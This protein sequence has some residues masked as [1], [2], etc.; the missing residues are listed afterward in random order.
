M[1]LGGAGW[2]G[3]GLFEGEMKKDGEVL[4]EGR[5]KGLKVCTFYT[6]LYKG[7]RRTF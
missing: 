1:G 4:K 6:G 7:W 2:V 3:N 5:T